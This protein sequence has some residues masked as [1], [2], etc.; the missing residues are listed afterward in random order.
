MLRFNLEWLM[1][2]EKNLMFELSQF[3]IIKDLNSY[4]CVYGLRK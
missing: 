4:K 1:Y 3:I 2:L